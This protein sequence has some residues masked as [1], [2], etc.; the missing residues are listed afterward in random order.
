MASYSK[1]M[2]PPSL[3]STSNAAFKYSKP[4][5]FISQPQ[6]GFLT[7]TR[8]S[9]SAPSWVGVEVGYNY[10]I[11]HAEMDM[12]PSQDPTTSHPLV[13]SVLELMLRSNFSR[14]YQ[15]ES[16]GTSEPVKEPANDRGNAL[17]AKLIAGAVLPPGDYLIRV[18]DDH[19]KEQLPTGRAC[20]PFSFDVAIV[21]AGNR[22]SV[23]S[24]NPLASVPLVRGV[25]VVLTVRFSEPPKG[26]IEECVVGQI[27]FAGM[28][29]TT[30]GSVQHFQSRY[31]DSNR[32]KTVVQASVSEG[33][34]VWVLA[35]SSQVFQKA[36]ATAELEIG[37]IRLVPDV[38]EV[39]SAPALDEV[40]WGSFLAF[41]WLDSL[42]NTG[43]QRQVNL[44]DSPPLA[45]QEDTARNT[46][47]YVRL[48][49]EQERAG[50]RHPLIHAIFW[51]FWPQ[52][53]LL[54]SMKI[55]QYLLGTGAYQ[56]KSSNSSPRTLAAMAAFCS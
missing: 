37:L 20:F 48:L 4:L 56:M 51:V 18:A 25:D 36:A 1:E 23:L 43:Y 42:V 55:S 8:I 6:Q 21:A 15:P 46:R 3:D 40:G 29:A 50:K 44:Q 26:S 22:P 19:Y 49:E 35:W 53:L 10:F 45:D 39:M 7:K 30:G 34:K 12:V 5:G 38:R 14:I 24:V 31:V 41:K 17:N 27:N 33:Q 28:Q 47:R 9:L 2:F 11:S 54:Q 16:W 13:L 32:P 52:L